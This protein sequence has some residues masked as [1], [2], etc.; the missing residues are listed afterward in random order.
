[1]FVD[2]HD[3][4]HHQAIYVRIQRADAVGKFLGQHGHGAIRK[5]NGSAAQARF[6]IERRSAANVMRHV[7]DVHLQLETAAGPRRDVHGVVEIA[8]RFAVN[9][10]DRQ[11]AEIAPPSNILF[12]HLLGNGLRL[13]QDFGANT[14]GR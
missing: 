1:M 4:A 10:D 5:I 12:A 2:L 8:R 13:R 11:V 7:G 3:R 14:C 6:A 9:G